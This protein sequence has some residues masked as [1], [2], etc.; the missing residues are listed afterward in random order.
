MTINVDTSLCPLCQQNNCCD[1][2]SP[3]G[4]WCLLEKVPNALIQKVPDDKKGQNCI[5][6][7][8]I[9]KFNLAKEDNF[10]AL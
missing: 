4:C 3:Q 8:C 1:V 6:Q 5:C 2:A 10:T 7:A 9:K